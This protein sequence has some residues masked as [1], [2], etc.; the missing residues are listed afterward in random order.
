MGVTTAFSDEAA[1]FS[2]ISED[3]LFVTS[4]LQSVSECVGLC[5]TANSWQLEGHS[6]TGG[7]DLNTVA[8][9]AASLLASAVSE[10]QVQPLQ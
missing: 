9:Q 5:R 2:R 4:V 3:P 8:L 6:G 7:A 10:S 1:D